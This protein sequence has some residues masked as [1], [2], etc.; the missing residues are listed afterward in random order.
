[1]GYCDASHDDDVDTRKGRGGYVF[2]SASADVNWKSTLLEVMTHSSCENGYL[3]LSVAGN[4]A[5]YLSQMQK[6][7]GVG[8]VDGVLLG[9]NESSM[10][11]AENPQAFQT[12]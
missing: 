12:Y 1:M 3:T 8:V 2:F 7:L 4:E 9:D 11:L 10:K 6:E 5:L